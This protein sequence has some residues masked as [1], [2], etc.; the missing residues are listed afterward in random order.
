MSSS[1]QDLFD[2]LCQGIRTGSVSYRE[3]ENVVY[4]LAITY[5]DGSGIE[6]TVRK[7]HITDEGN[8]LHRLL[9][10]DRM[11][12]VKKWGDN[13][14]SYLA[15]H[16]ARQDG[17]ELI[18]IGKKPSHLVRYVQGL[19]DLEAVMPE[20]REISRDFDD[21]MRKGVEKELKKLV[22]TNKI[23]ASDFERIL[24]A[25]FPY[26][27]QTDD[28][29]RTISIDAD[30]FNKPRTEMVV[31][32]AHGG[33]TPADRLKHIK[34]KLGEHGLLRKA[35]PV[36]TLAVMPADSHYSADDEVLIRAFSG[37]APRAVNVTRGPKWLAKHLV[38]PTASPFD[39]HLSD[40]E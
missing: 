37:Q 35:N 19:R 36:R 13:F 34:N 12:D 33:G 23:T 1:Q 11:R 4:E 32:L 16:H 22:E 28:G 6:L 8:T 26:N 17:Y 25:T 3:N 9:A 31:V 7:D 38:K 29:T 40:D 14:Q 21:Q 15:L 2:I 24:D 5:L 10:E 30:F 27:V 18:Y 20:T 39:G